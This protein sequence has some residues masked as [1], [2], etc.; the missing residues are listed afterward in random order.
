MILDGATAPKQAYTIN[1]EETQYIALT[2]Q[3]LDEAEAF[4]IAKEMYDEGNLPWEGVDTHYSNLYGEGNPR[5][6]TP[7]N[8]GNDTGVAI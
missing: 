3:A 8:I 2:V 5:P 6:Q 7:T 4:R 1:I